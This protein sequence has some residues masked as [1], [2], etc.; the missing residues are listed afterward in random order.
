MS[1]VYFNRCYCKPQEL[2]AQSAVLRS[3]LAL[4]LWK[5]EWICPILGSPNHWLG[6]LGMDHFFTVMPHCREHLEEMQCS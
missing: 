6:P 3:L 1:G 5:Y 2:R 4:H